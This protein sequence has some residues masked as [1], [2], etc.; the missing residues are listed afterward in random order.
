MTARISNR[1]WFAIGAGSG[2]A[3]TAAVITLW[4][5]VPVYCSAMEYID[6]DPIRLELSEAPQ[7]AHVF[8]CFGF[9]CAPSR[10]EPDASGTFAVPQS[11]PYLDLTSSTLGV[12]ATG[13][14][15]EVRVDNSTVTANR[16]GIERIS[17]TPFWSRCAGPFHYGTVN[18]GG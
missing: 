17:E 3:V 6:P 7:D 9:D 10:V 15:V 8:A 13:V 18:V 1:G 5:V 16:F 4:T 11:E 14:Y 2:I 12:S